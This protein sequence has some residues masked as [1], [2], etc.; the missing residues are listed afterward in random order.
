M[1]SC[2]NQKTPRQ[3]NINRCPQSVYKMIDDFKK[4]IESND[5]EPDSFKVDD[6]TLIDI[7][8]CLGSS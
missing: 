8:E 2:V 4:H 5:S 1:I 7:Y 6:L 3:I